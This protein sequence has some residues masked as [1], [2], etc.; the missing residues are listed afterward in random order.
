LRNSPI[1]KAVQNVRDS[2]VSIRGEKTLTATASPASGI[3]PGK[4]V[5]GMGT[6]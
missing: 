6:A 1:V 4:H 3:E 2:V 5:N